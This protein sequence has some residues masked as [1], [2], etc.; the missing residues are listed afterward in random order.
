MSA[1][2]KPSEADAELLATAASYHRMFAEDIAFWETAGDDPGNKM[3]DAQNE[4]DGRWTLMSNAVDRVAEL[5]A[6]T[7]AGIKAKASV[8]DVLIREQHK[9]RLRRA[10]KTRK[11]GWRCR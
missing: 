4:P 8:L 6:T 7:C 9:L 3:A 2:R 11:S 5:P 10:A 1:L